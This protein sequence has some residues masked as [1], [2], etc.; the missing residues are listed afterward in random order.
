MQQEFHLV[1]KQNILNVFQFAKSVVVVTHQY[2]YDQWDELRD[3][4]SQS[5]NQELCGHALRI[6]S[7]LG[8]TSDL[9]E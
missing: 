8:D 7:A 3:S 4:D 5:Q 6:E 1:T 9:E 2:P